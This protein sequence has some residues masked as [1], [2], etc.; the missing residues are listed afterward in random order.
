MKSKIEVRVVH[1]VEL[2][3]QVRL[4]T[5]R[6][7]LL[8]EVKLRREGLRP[9]MSDRVDMFWVDTQL[10]SL[11]IEPNLDNPEKF[12]VDRAGGF[13]PNLTKEVVGQITEWFKER[14]EY[15]QQVA[16][17]QKLIEGGYKEV[18][19]PKGEPCPTCMHY[20]LQQGK[21]AHREYEGRL[22][23]ADY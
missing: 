5:D 23:P 4:I 13:K 15:L 21:H 1:R 8:E 11:V 3:L 2:E 18:R 16:W 9:C 7:D 20:F 6:Q 22:W 14:P 12:T 19:F 17:T 10:G